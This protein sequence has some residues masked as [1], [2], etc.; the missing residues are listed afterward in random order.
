M[1]WNIGN[2]AIGD[3]MNWGDYGDETADTLFLRRFH[4]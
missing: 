2:P 3:W 1:P 4:L